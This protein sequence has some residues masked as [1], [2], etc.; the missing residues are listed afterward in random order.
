MP[1]VDSLKC[2]LIAARTDSAGVAKTD[3][4][5]EEHRLLTSML[6]SQGYGRDAL[7][8]ALNSASFRVRQDSGANMH[9]RVGNG[10][11]TKRDTYVL[12][13]STAGQGAYAVRMDAAYV[14][15]TVPTTDA[16]LPQKYSV[17]LFVDDATYSG[18]A[19][20]A[21]V[22]LT[23]LRG[24]P[25]ASPVAPSP[26][27]AWSAYARLCT[28]ELPAGAS[29][30]TDAIL[31][32]GSDDRSPS[33]LLHF[34]GPQLFTWSMSGVLAVASGG[35]GFRAPIALE[36]QHVRLSVS[37]APTGA[38]LLVDVNKNG[39]TMFTT[40]ANRPTIA[41]G[42]YTETAIT[43]PDV[44]SIAAGDRITV[45]IDQVGSTIAGSNL[46]VVAYCLQV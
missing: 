25:N 15:L 44:V 8:G 13:G 18:T 24:T 9:V 35:L 41:A 36:L 4:D 2:H 12:R 6:M 38:A 7:T 21:R 43:A 40:Q 31:A 1:I 17:F 14:D 26:D 27:A 45:D 22:G 42:A 29:A 37:T 46:V 3:V 11:N 16:G 39:T 10:T 23:C 5:Q 30:V 28:F 34:G 19:A 33:S 32:A 20:R